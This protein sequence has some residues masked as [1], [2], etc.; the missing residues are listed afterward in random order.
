LT[1]SVKNVKLVSMKR[2]P[3]RRKLDRLAGRFFLFA[4]FSIIKILP[5]RFFYHFAFA[6]GTTAYY[7]MAKHRRLTISNLK[8]AFGGSKTEAEYRRLAR[9]VFR[10]I[11]VGACETTIAIIYKDKEW[12]KKQIKIEGIENLHKAIKKG[13]GVIAL[14]AHFGNFT[15]MCVRLSQEDFSF[16][17]VIRDPNDEAVT[18]LFIK[19]R[20]RLNVEFI[21]A[22][23]RNVCVRKS[24]EYLHQNGVLCLMA[25]QSK[26]KGVVVKF[27]GQFVGAVAGPAIMAIRTG[28]PILPMFILKE[29][30]GAHKIV[31][32]EP[33]E[34]SL[35][36]NNDKDVYE[37]SQKFTKVIEDYARR[38]PDQWW[39]VH[40]RWKH[41]PKNQDSV[42]RS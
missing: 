37:A 1:Y 20:K 26:S 36:G 42:V 13:K 5:E 27:F 35:T 9:D 16:K 31:I 3:Y 4:S 29:G 41:A 2:H 22:R 8:R 30:G 6:L 17:T 11:A 10:E 40:Q 23:P 15:L 38:Y 18:E 34:V 32:H 19:L 12:I 25:D 24:L 21:S 28:A 33:I 7:L 14:S 39:W